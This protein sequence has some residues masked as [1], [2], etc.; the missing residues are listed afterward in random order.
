MMEDMISYLWM[1][2]ALL[3]NPLD[4]VL[5]QHDDSLDRCVK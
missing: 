3:S 4:M 5:D 2:T 1:V